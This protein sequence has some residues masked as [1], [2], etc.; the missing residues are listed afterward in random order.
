MHRKRNGKLV[1]IWSLTHFLWGLIAA[2][3]MPVWFAAA[4]LVLWEP[5]ENFVISPILWRYLKINFGHETLQNSLSDIVFDGLGLL[6]GIS[7]L[8]VV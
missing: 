7:I 8:T 2:L 4:L 5:L 6:A 1:D 3:L